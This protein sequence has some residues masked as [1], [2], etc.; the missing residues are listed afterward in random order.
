MRPLMVVPEAIAAAAIEHDGLVFSMPKPARHH[1]IIHAMSRIG[2][3][4]EKVK[5]QG[6]L[7]SKGEFV[8][9]GVARFIAVR[10]GQIDDRKSH[11]PNHLFSEDL[12]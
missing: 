7:T 6:F 9:R 11:H 1:H 8:G 4:P 3:G 12:W 2:L 10:A 5:N